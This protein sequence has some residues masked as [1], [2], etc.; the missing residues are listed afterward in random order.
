MTSESAAV[1]GEAA[2]T[3]SPVVTASSA[4]SLLRFNTKTQTFDKPRSLNP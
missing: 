1:A 2:E 4:K 3:K